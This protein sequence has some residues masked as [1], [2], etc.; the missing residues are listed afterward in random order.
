MRTIAMKHLYVPLA[1]AFLALVLPSTARASLPPSPEYIPGPTYIDDTIAVRRDLNR[2]GDFGDPGEGF[3]YYLTDHQ[4]STVALLDA[5]GN[6]VERYGYDAFG[7]PT[8]YDGNGTPITQTAYG[9]NR[10]SACKDTKR[11]LVTRLRDR[12][13]SA[14]SKDNALRSGA[15]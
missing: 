6:V 2:D 7:A 4:H 13:G 12:R 14:A 10:L 8:F 5:S 1:F 9:N 15:S 3:L 11:S